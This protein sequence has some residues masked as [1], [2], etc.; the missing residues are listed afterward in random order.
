MKCEACERKVGGDEHE[1]TDQKP[2]RRMALYADDAVR[3]P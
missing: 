1:L 3:R 2:V